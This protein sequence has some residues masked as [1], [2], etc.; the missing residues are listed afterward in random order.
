MKNR[1]IHILTA[2]DCVERIQEYTAKYSLNQFETDR[3]TQDAVLRNLEILGQSIKD[4]GIDDLII[5]YPNI[6]WR[7]LAGMR[8]I[9]AHDYLS[10][11]I[12]I[13]WETISKHIVPLEKVIKEIIKELKNND[14]L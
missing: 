10:I 11:D 1:L 3:K 9:I 6:E 4:Y 2:L 5:D 13:I 12:V 7:S 8:N 14:R